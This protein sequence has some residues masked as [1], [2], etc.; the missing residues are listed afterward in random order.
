MAMRRFEEARACYHR[1]LEIDPD[2]EIA[3]ER[4]EDVERIL[5]LPPR[6]TPLIG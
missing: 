3:K 5:R 4:L 1:A 2:Y 6:D